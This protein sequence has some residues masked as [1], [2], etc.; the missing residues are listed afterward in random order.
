MKQQD[1]NNKHT[2]KNTN[3][4]VEELLNEIEEIASS[5]VYN[6][7]ILQSW[8]KKFEENLG[9]ASSKDLMKCLSAFVELKQYN[10]EFF[11][12]ISEAILQKLSKS[13][14]SSISNCIYYLAKLGYY[15]QEFIKSYI[16]FFNIYAANATAEDLSRIIWATSKFRYHDEQ[17][18]NQWSDLAIQIITEFTPIDLSQSILSITKLGYYKESFVCNWLNQAASQISSFDNQ[19]LINSAFALTMIMKINPLTE[20]VSAN[21][22]DFIIILA[23]NIKY[24]EIEIT[25]EKRQL[26]SVFYAMDKL[27]RDALPDIQAKLEAWNEEVKTDSSVSIS[28]IQHKIFEYIHKTHKNAIEEH[29]MIELGTSVDIFDP[30]NNIIFQVDGSAH[31][32]KN[33]GVEDAATRFNTAMIAPHATIFRITNFYHYESYINDIYKT[34]R[35]NQHQEK[36]QKELS[37]SSAKSNNLFLALDDS[38]V[39]EFIE[40]NEMYS[41]AVAFVTESH[42]EQTKKQKETKLSD[43]IADESAQDSAIKNNI[44]P[45]CLNTKLVKAFIEKHK[46]ELG[47]N[48]DLDAVLGLAIERQNPHAVEWILKE[49]DKKEELKTIISGN[50]SIIKLINKKELG[51]KEK[52]DAVKIVQKFLEYPNITIK[53]RM[54]LREYTFSKIAYLAIEVFN[55]KVLQSLIE[56]KL[57]NPDLSLANGVTLLGHACIKNNL[58]AVEILLSEGANPNKLSNGNSPLFMASGESDLS[59]MR[60]LLENDARP[61]TVAV[62]GS[63]PLHQALRGNNKDKIELLLNFGANINVV[64]KSGESI[65][66]LASLHGYI[67]LVRTIINEGKTDV[68]I[69]S[70]QD[71]MTPLMAAIYLKNIEIVKVLLDAG[72]NID[73][74]NK[75][76]QTA[77]F[78]AIENNAREAVRLFLH[79]HADPDLPIKIKE[80]NGS[81]MFTNL[82]LA[83][84][85]GNL[86][87]VK[88]LLAAGANVNSVMDN[89]SAI[90]FAEE[91]LKEKEIPVEVYNEI[92]RFLMKPIDYIAEY[93]QPLELKLNALDRLSKREGITEEMSTKIDCMIN[94]LLS[95]NTQ[96]I[97]ESKISVDEA[98]QELLQLTVKVAITGEETQN[99]RAQESIKQLYNKSEKTSFSVD[100]GLSAILESM[101]NSK[102]LDDLIGTNESYALEAG[103]KWFFKSF[104]KWVNYLSNSLNALLHM[105]NDGNLLEAMILQL[106]GL[107]MMAGSGSLPMGVPHHYNPNDDDFEPDFGGGNSGIIFNNMPERQPQNVYVITVLGNYTFITE[108]SHNILN[109][110]L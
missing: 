52:E 100:D 65:L 62:D 48:S 26:I 77:L 44:Q 54:D 38:K 59:L 30:I 90:E 70:R 11:K 67:D 16:E 53:P 50:H 42:V 66:F 74:K 49:M 17:F 103:N 55:T 64:D 95:S 69:A 37:V 81:I 94:S 56:R 83:I 109:D 108:D 7:A 63:T 34:L 41:E 25:E 23:T 68:N 22:K 110:I 1:K 80:E 15:N 61:N 98:A 79:N 91:L 32:Y 43:K 28:P 82:A 24:N 10:E 2:I 33:D 93:D 102:S 73:I 47:N 29:W 99:E 78:L 5:D 13:D 6:T 106:Q 72:V 88:D 9:A 14:M 12:K 51:Q 8:I 87:I 57:V 92:A 97:E 35:T 86:D 36:M 75:H 89:I 71:Q 4:K 21:I 40:S 45:E 60:L 46:S 19:G 39:D 18:C 31:R 84:Q 85:T 107:L 58:E 3:K 27:R 101:F 105:E 20:T 104:G 76:G 96:S